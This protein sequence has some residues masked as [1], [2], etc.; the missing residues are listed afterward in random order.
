MFV[1]ALSLIF[2]VPVLNGQDLQPCPSALTV[3]ITD[4]DLKSD[5]SIRKDG[6]VYNKSDYFHSED[7]MILGCVC[8]IKFCVRKCCNPDEVMSNNTCVKGEKNV[9]F[10]VYNGTH[11][12]TKEKDF[13]KIYNLY[14]ENDNFQLFP[15]MSDPFHPDNFYIQQNGSVYIPNLIPEKP[16]HGPEEYCVEN[17][18]K[19]DQPAT[20]S[21][22]FC[23]INDD[24]ELEEFANTGKKQFIIF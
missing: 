7:G 12:S 6:I 1:C 10:D 5:G 18:V 20:F 15:N 2:L 16:M 19:P 23:T 22:L 24:Y 14:C 4:G 3:N 9:S 21:V 13:Y 11:L 8:N 17:F